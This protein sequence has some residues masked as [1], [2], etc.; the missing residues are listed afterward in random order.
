[1]T[2]A[3]FSDEFRL[4]IGY[5]W[6]VIVPTRNSVHTCV[7][8]IGNIVDHMRISLQSFPFLRQCRTSNTLVTRKSISKLGEDFTLATAN[9]GGHGTSTWPNFKS[10]PVSST[11]SIVPAVM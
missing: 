1:M 8:Y 10:R 2:S 3:Y 4:K 7:F 9:L 6:P 11:S 5:S